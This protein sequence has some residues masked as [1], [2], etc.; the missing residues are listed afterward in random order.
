L[1]LLFL[2]FDFL[3]RCCNLTP[4]KYMLTN[5]CIASCCCNTLIYTGLFSARKYIETEEVSMAQYGTYQ[6]QKPPLPSIQL[7]IIKLRENSRHKFLEY[8]GK[9]KV[10]LYGL[11]VKI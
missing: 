1:L 7:L 9:L 11:G 2:Y 5:T 3:I 4:R 10:K 8:E 6:R